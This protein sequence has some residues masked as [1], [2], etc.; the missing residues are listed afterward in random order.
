MVYIP[1]KNF[2]EYKPYFGNAVVYRK[3]G[4]ISEMRW[5]IVMGWYKINYNGDAVVYRKCGGITDKYRFIFYL[6]STL[7][8]FLFALL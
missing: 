4:G 7:R 1:R 5:F 8:T 3:C 2:G 6:I